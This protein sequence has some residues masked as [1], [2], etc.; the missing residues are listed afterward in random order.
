[1]NRLSL[2]GKV[3]T[4]LGVIEPEALGATLMHEH[5][6]LDINPPSA[7]LPT[8]PE[9]EISLANLFA[10]NYQ[11]V[12]HFGNARL[13]DKTV[14]IDELDR[15]RKSGGKTVV[16]LSCGGL[17][18]DPIGLREI[19]KAT[20][21]NVV[22]GGGHYVQEFQDPANMGRTADSFAEEMIEQVHKG[23]WGTDVKVGIFGE[24]GCS[25]PWTDLE[26]RVMQGAVVAQQETGVAIS[27]HVALLPDQP[28]EVIGFIKAAGGNVERTVISHIDRTVQDEERL[29]RLAGTGCT[30]EYDYFGNEKTYW[31]IG[32]VD[33]PNDGVRLKF[34]RKLIDRGHLSQIA[35]SHDLCRKTRLVKFGGHGYGHIFDN[36]L[37][38]MRAR[39]FSETEIDAILVQ[40]PRRLLTIA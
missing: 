7:P 21:V 9:P 29:F 32:K 1:M 31:P 39:G 28:Q 17:K 25:K 10:L 13:D 40:N 20:G 37:P 16:E 6:L 11:R 23:A 5:I 8:K 33:L 15:L 35:I 26:K 24:I 3:Q 36:V 27:V 14:A 12:V 2:Q 38:L 34:I 18:P 30:I 22:M 19:S 4:V